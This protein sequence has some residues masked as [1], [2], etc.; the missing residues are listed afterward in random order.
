MPAAPGSQVTP[1]GL[2]PIDPN[3]V[4]INQAAQGAMQQ[5][6]DPAMLEGML[7]Q[8]ADGMGDLEDAEDY[9]TVINSIRGDELPMEQRYAELS[10]I[11][12][13]E[14]SQA[15]PE[16]VLTLLQPVMLM[17]AVDQGIG[18]LAAQEMSAPIEGP[19]AEGIMSTVNMGAP[20]APVQVPGGPAPVN[21]NQGGAVQYMATSLV[22]LIKKL[23]LQTNKK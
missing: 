14:D 23:S 11:V 13:L 4:D 8:Y 1:P 9:E 17:A 2:P 15:T 12:G 10:E 19:L 22:W 3:S 21:F 6:I 5:G 20:E 18:G 7:T 16:S